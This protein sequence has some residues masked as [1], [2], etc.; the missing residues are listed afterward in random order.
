MQGIRW[1][2]LQKGEPASQIPEIQRILP[3]NL[4]SL[5]DGC[6]RDRDFADTAA[7]VANLDLVITTDTAVAHLAGAL[8][9]PLWLLL[10]WQS[11]WRWM[12]DRLTTPWYPTARLFRQSSPNN[13]PELIARVA[14]ELQILATVRD[15]KPTQPSL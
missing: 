8:G 2:S 13:W 10:P 9:K 14:S 6:S 12:Q 11:D 5:H 3:P 7:L 1:I 4:S 15:Q